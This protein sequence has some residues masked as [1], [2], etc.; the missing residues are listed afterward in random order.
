MPRQIQPAAVVLQHIDDPQAL[1]VVVEAARH[2]CVDDALS[3]VA[4]RRVAEIVTERDRL[5]QLLVQTQDFRDRARYL[6]NLQGVGQTRAIVIAGRRKKDLRLV[7]QTP[8]RLAVDD[9]IAVTLI[10][11]PD[12]VLGFRTAA[13]ARIGALGRLRRK[14]LTLARFELL[15]K[16]HEMR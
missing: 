2:Q 5:G 13:A 3:S 4:E 14:C 6:R 8:E 7:L 9:P 12:L 16:I 15:T 1:F 10:G 11:R